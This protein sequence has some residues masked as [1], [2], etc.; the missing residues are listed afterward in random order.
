MITFDA[1]GHSVLTASSS[2]DCLSKVLLWTEGLCPHPPPPPTPNSYFETL[3]HNMIVFG[4][5]RALGGD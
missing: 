3:T 2:S 4:G 5:G 1:T